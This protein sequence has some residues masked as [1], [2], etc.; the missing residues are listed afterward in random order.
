[1]RLRRSPFWAASV[2]GGS[3]RARCPQWIAQHSI[4]GQWSHLYAILGN[5]PRKIGGD[6]FRRVDFSRRRVG[7]NASPS[8]SEQ[9]R[10]GIVLPSR[11]T[12]FHVKDERA[13]GL[14]RRGLVKCVILR[15]GPP[16]TWIAPHGGPQ[17]RAIHSNARVRRIDLKLRDPRICYC[18]C[19]TGGL[20]V[21]PDQSPTTA[22]ESLK[23]SADSIFE[24][25]FGRAVLFPSSSS[26]SAFRS[27]VHSCL[28]AKVFFDAVFHFPRPTSA[29]M[30]RIGRDGGLLRP[31]RAACDGAGPLPMGTTPLRERHVG[32][33]RGLWR[34]FAAKPSVR[35]SDRWK[36]LRLRRLQ[37]F[38]RVL[39]E[40]LAT[41]RESWSLVGAVRLHSA[42][43]SLT[44]LRIPVPTRRADVARRQ[45]GPQ[46]ELLV[47]RF[48]SAC[49]HLR[50]APGNCWFSLFWRNTILRR[51]P[52]L[53]HL[54]ASSWG[55]QAGCCDKVNKSDV[56]QFWG[57]GIAELL[58]LWCRETTG[59]QVAN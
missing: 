48:I 52:G 9:G 16:G 34:I 13:S 3:W 47:R 33:C 10:I 5:G 46:R 36:R 41:L 30:A 19:G 6:W 56:L 38:C 8:W 21:S 22:A 37:D 14:T 28:R 55:G 42:S 35:K 24:R 45:G 18:G 57:A 54:H 2:I 23:S 53:C 17:L 11:R 25:R 39:T 40:R 26:A 1:L 15:P 43:L 32:R 51:L 7:G 12:A 59:G 50:F 27:V 29:G 49:C 4:V 58:Q 31:D 44:L 20:Q